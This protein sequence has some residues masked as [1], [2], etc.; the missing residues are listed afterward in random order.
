MKHPPAHPSGST[1]SLKA[2][3][4]L[5]IVVLVTLI[6]SVFVIAIWEIKVRL[7]AVAFGHMAEDQLTLMMSESTDPANTGH[8][9]A[10][11]LEAVYR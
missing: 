5:A 6:S 3:L 8:A 2:R 9:T 11:C 4:I 7:E 10:S 1:L